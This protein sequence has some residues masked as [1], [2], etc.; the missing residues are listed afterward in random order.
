M[1]SLASPATVG[2]CVGPAFVVYAYA[3]YPPLIWLLS[4]CF[5]RLADAPQQLPCAAL[6]TGAP[7]PA[8]ARSL[9]G[10]AREVARRRRGCDRQAGA[11]EA[12]K[13]GS[14]DSI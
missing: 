5:V 9:S 1:N 10:A 13:R 14:A 2:F 3:V 12:A 4:H 8:P 7:I 11:L 6:P